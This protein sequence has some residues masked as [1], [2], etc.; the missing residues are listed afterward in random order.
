VLPEARR[1]VF[2]Q[3][4]EI[5][6]DFTIV[7]ITIT[8]K[9]HFI[10]TRFFEPFSDQLSNNHWWSIY[11]AKNR[12]VS[13]LSETTHSPKENGLQDEGRLFILGM[14]LKS[15]IFFYRDVFA[16]IQCQYQ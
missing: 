3:F 13:I 4:H 16:I 2:E 5:F 10:L 15:R 11:E 12:P 6:S 7:A 9:H 14:L 8:L 1:H